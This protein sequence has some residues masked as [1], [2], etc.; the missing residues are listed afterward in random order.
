MFDLTTFNP[1]PAS[2][3]RSTFRDMEDFERSFF[4]SRF[5]PAFRTDIRDT[6]D[7]YLLEADLPGMKKED[8]HIDINGNR[9]TI[10]AERNAVN[11]DKGDGYIRCE[12]SYG[13]FSRGFDISGIQA[14]NIGAAYEDG[15]L[16]LTLPK[17]AK[18]L[19]ESRRLEIQ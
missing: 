14:E 8:I 1:S 19:P 15:V 17:K 9:L 2:L 7:A 6:G 12:R 13:S 3:F 11:E 5:T 10:S 4:G 18:A 16:K